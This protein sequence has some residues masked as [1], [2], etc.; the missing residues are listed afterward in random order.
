MKSD[1]FVIQKVSPQEALSKFLSV[2][3]RVLLKDAICEAYR[4]VPMDVEKVKWYTDKFGPSMLSR[5]RS[6]GIAYFLQM[7]QVSKQLGIKFSIQ[8]NQTGNAR[9]LLGAT[10]DG[11]CCFTVNQVTNAKHSSNR[12]D[13][14]QTKHQSF[15]SYF[16]LF[17]EGELIVDQPLYFELNH[18][19]RGQE[20][21]FVVLGIPNESRGWYASDNILVSAPLSVARDQTMKSVANP[22]KEYNQEDFQKFIFGKGGL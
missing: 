14:R 1:N 9:Y 4:Q 3:Q 20:P 21:K 13:F 2:P 7:T 16:D 10:N 22:I 17:G 12:A 8:K 19:Y 11:R 5:L 15:E 6:M 18:G